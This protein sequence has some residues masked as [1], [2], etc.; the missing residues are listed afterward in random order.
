M[1]TKII[2]FVFL[3]TTFFLSALSTKIYAEEKAAGPSATFAHIM[4]Q[5]REDH[6]VK[7]I[8]GYLEKNNSPLAPYADIFVAQADINSIPWDLLV[9]MSG[10]ESTFGQQVPV[11]CNNAW[12][13]GIYGDQ[14]LCFNSYPEAIATIS[15]AI[16]SQYIDKWGAKDVFDIG[17]TYASSP[18]W[19]I[20][21]DYFMHEVED[22]QKELQMQDLPISI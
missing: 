13:F 3:L 16:R 10:T 19:G 21:T 6:R 17:K 5:Q 15:K 8:K 12:G 1:K 11:N 18:M 14:T 20:H 9:A 2:S 22:Y 7:S 4:T